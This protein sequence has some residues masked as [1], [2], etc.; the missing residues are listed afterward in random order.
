MKI[1]IT[2]E[3]ITITLQLRDLYAPYEGIETVE[4]E[5]G[6]TIIRYYRWLDWKT[7][8]PIWR[9]A[10]GDSKRGSSND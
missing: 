7:N 9:G 3:K 10:P 4:T 5:N 8:P 6:P 2:T 1:T